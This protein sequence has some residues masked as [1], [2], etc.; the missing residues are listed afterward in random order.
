MSWVSID[1]DK[2]TICGTCAL[3]CPRCYMKGEDEIAAY[4]DENN[5]NICGHCV[6]LCPEDAI[7]HEMVN[8]SNFIEIGEGVNFDTDEFTRFI[9]QRRSHRAFKDKQVPREELENLIDLCRYAPTG[10]NVQLVEIMV[11]QDAEKKQRL[12]DLTVDYFIE[13][14]AKA[15]K[16]LEGEKVEGIDKSV[17]PQMMQLAVH[18]SGLL[19]MARE[20]G[21]DAI[22]HKAPTAIIFHSSAEARTPKDD[23]VIAS[24][25]M[26]LAARTMGLESTYIGLIEAAS[27]S[28]KAL[29]EELD[30]PEGHEVHSVLIMGYPKLKFLKT[31]DRKSI[32]TTWV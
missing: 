10:G 31:V 17:T 12:S 19:Q 16:A 25:T 7:I 26:G 20:M 29:I 28:H 15:E 27:K 13:M 18:Y 21:Y 4:A 2:C 24:T 5:C 22:F 30:L 1:K 11:I 9:R 14:G 32:K 23:C 3:R 6:A 8:L